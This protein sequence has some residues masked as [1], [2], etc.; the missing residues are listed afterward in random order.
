M[1]RDQPDLRAHG[2][3]E[4]DEHER[5]RAAAVDGRIEL[6]VLLLPHAHVVGVGRAEGLRV[7]IHVEGQ[8]VPLVALDNQ[9]IAQPKFPYAQ[10]LPKLLEVLR[11]QKLV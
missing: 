8:A 6:A 7:D 3:V 2:R 10:V 4:A 1:A 9:I 5:V 11:K